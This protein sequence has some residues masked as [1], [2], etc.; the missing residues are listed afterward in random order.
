MSNPI[1][2][3]DEEMVG[4]M[5]PMLRRSNS[6]DNVRVNKCQPPDYPGEWRRS[7]ESLV[8]VASNDIRMDEMRHQMINAVQS[9]RETQRELQ[10]IKEELQ[11]SKMEHQ[12]LLSAKPL[13][14]HVSRLKKA[15]D[16][17]IAIARSQLYKRKETERR[18][19]VNAVAEE[20]DSKEGQ[21]I[22]AAVN[23]LQ[24][25]IRMLTGAAAAADEP[26]AL[27]PSMVQQSAP[28][29]TVEVAP[30]I[31]APEV[32]VNV[33][34][35]IYAPLVD[36][37]TLEDPGQELEWQPEDTIG[38]VPDESENEPGNEPDDIGKEGAYVYE[39]I[40]NSIEQQWKQENNRI[41]DQDQFIAKRDSMEAKKVTPDDVII[42]IAQRMIAYELFY[43]ELD[44]LENER[45]E[46]VRALTV[47]KKEIKQYEKHRLLIEGRLNKMK[48]DM[49]ENVRNAAAE[50]DKIKR[51]ILT[52]KEDLKKAKNTNT[53]SKC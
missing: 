45:G 10:R 42:V 5:Y 51:E 39:E 20:E 16:G 27:E 53:K 26:L 19:M 15:A 52:L 24:N 14:K 11:E 31:M 38:N 37:T 50:K 3:P 18:H 1:V 34:P 13:L 44:A 21:A 47:Q 32:T 8:S 12:N 6:Y 29:D 40:R 48:D 9:E 23:E 30:E 4:R 46:E 17:A 25:K 35:E 41:Q 33:L 7:E 49:E 28:T 36:V 43:N 2:S 22:V